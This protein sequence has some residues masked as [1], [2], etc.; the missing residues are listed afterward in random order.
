M[1]ASAQDPWRTNPPLGLVRHELG[2]AFASLAFGAE[3]C[4]ISYDGNGW[5]S[6]V[7]W[8]VRQPSERAVLASWLGGTVEPEYMSGEDVCVCSSIPKKLK[9]EILT[10]LDDVFENLR[11][12]DVRKLLDLSVQMGRDGKLVIE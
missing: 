9:F 12:L 3:R 2:H 5:R 6:D 7:Q 11:S 1:N 8:K 4:I 10:E